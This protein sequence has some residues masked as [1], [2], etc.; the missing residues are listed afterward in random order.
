M[1]VILWI[2]I[3]Y[4]LQSYTHV[5]GQYSYCLIII[6]LLNRSHKDASL[7]KW[8]WEVG[9]AEI[10]KFQLTFW[11]A[12]LYKVLCAKI[13][14]IWGIAEFQKQT[15]SSVLN[16]FNKLSSLYLSTVYLQKRLISSVKHSKQREQHASG[17]GRDIRTLKFGTADSPSLVLWKGE[18][19]ETEQPK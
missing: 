11:P 4:R 8:N 15:L 12:K 6:K 18:V 1:F 5:E 13:F 16:H 10:T 14:I 9:Q 17:H 3:I 19:S 7:S 2:E